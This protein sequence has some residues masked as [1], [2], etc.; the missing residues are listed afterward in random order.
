MAIR[1]LSHTGALGAA[2]VN[3]LRLAFEQYLRD[4]PPSACVENMLI[5]L[6]ITMRLSRL[7][8]FAES[9]PHWHFQTKTN[10]ALDGPLTNADLH[11]LLEFSL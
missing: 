2:T 8:E 11:C 5:L 6:Q 1:W 4:Q 9:P 3:E 7:P 10:I